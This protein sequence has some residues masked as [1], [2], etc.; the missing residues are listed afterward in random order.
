MHQLGHDFNQSGFT[1]PVFTDET[2]DVSFFDGQ[3]D[4]AQSLLLA[5]L[6]ADPL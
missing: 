6:F 1:S 4:I 5:E 3:V 2:V